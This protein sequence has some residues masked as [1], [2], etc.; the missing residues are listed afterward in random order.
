MGYQGNFE[1]YR[2][3][4]Q[5]NSNRYNSN[6]LSYWNRYKNTGI[7]HRHISGIN[8]GFIRKILDLF[9]YGKLNRRFL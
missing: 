6:K 9:K 2:N 3:L 4:S 1:S 8:K 5:D 7:R